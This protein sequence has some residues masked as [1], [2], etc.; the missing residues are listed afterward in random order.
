M[1]FSSNRLR[2]WLV[3]TGPVAHDAA[4]GKATL[5]VQLRNVSDGVVH[6]PVLLRA[7]DDEGREW[8]FTGRMGSHDRFPPGGLIEPVK[9]EIETGAGV[10]AR[11][12]FQIFGRVTR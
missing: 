10:D 12:N 2:N 9:V 6:G 4:G 1:I 7:V 11:L 5:D 8:S 3:V